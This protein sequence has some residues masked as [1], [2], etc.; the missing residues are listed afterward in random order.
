[1]FGAEYNAIKNAHFS[2]YYTETD[3]FHSTVFFFLTSACLSKPC[4]EL[5]I[6][7][8]CRNCAFLL[9]TLGKGPETIL[10]FVCAK[11]FEINSALQHKSPTKISHPSNCSFYLRLSNEIVSQS[12]LLLFTSRNKIFYQYFFL[13][14]INYLRHSCWVEFVC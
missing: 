4:K 8:K 13:P 6:L 7:H 9:L 5:A 1:M 11:Q 14:Y 3:W 12:Y 2:R 10:I